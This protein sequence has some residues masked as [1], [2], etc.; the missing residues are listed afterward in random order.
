M[1]EFKPPPLPVREKKK[2][3][4]IDDKSNDQ[5]QPENKSN[6]KSIPPNHVIGENGEL[7]KLLYEVPFWSHKPSYPYVLEVI[8][9][10]SLIEE[11]NIHEKGHYL[12]GRAPICDIILDNPV[13]IY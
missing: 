9:D 5:N 2:K 7:V 12:I 11:I 4:Q 3:S 8:K 10:G 6:E 1:S 13:C